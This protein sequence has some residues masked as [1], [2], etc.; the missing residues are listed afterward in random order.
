MTPRTFFLTGCASGIGRH[1][2]D[3]LS[4]RGHR[5]VASDINELALRDH[6]HKAGW[7]TETTKAVGLDVSDP[8]AWEARLDETMKW[9]GSLDVVLNVAGYLLPGWV[10]ELETSTIHRHFDVNIKGTIFGTVAAARRMVAQGSGHIINVASLAALAPIPGLALY[11][12]SKYAVRSFSL[13]AAQELR[14]KGVFVTVVCP[15]VVQTPMLDLQRGYEQAVLS[16]SGKR[17]LTVEEVGEVIFNRVLPSAPLE[18]F[19]PATRGWLARVAD[20]FPRT[21]EWVRPV[22]VRRG[23]KRQADETARRR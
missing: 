6:A 14:S 4:S 18:V 8:D 19:F 17:A 16:F 10:H 3:E 22:L 20:V 7:P 13:A 23:R 11:S 2:A 1:L 5:V 12:A 15:D 9:F 21:I